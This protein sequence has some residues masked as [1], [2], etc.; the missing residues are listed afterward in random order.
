MIDPDDGHMNLS[1]ILIPI[2][3]SPAPRYPIAYTVDMLKEMNITGCKLHLLHV[4]KDATFPKVEIPRSDDFSCEKISVTGD[5]VATILTTANDLNT[6]L[7]VMATH[8]HD[9]FLDA[10]RGSISERVLRESLCPVLTLPT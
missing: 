2:D 7:I 5:T 10:L 9:G 4:G 6:S 3:H 1:N 8:G